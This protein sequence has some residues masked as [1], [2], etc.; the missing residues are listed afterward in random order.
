M[1]HNQ[2]P[3]K[4]SKKR[5]GSALRLEGVAPPQLPLLR[6][7]DNKRCL[8]EPKVHLVLSLLNYSLGAILLKLNSSLVFDK[9]T[10]VAKS[11]PTAQKLAAPPRQGG[12]LRSLFLLPWDLKRNDRIIYV[13]P[14][15]AK[16]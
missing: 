3:R 10:N 1:L 16:T 13:M 11:N 8:K 12:P 4:N 6:F 2:F 7:L 5:S 9:T 14:C 15:H